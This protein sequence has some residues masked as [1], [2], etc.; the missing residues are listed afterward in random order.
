MV[1]SIQFR[2]SFDPHSHANTRTFP[3]NVV[4]ISVREII[5]LSLFRERSFSSRSFPPSLSL[6][7]SLQRILQPNAFYASSARPASVLSLPQHVRSLIVPLS[8]TVSPSSTCNHARI[9][10]T[11][12]RIHAPRTYS[13]AAHKN[14]PRDVLSL[15]GA[16]LA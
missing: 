5:S 12:A 4:T 15:S 13:H 10:F 1:L 9:L 16:H 8:P 2:P 6:S 3:R 14:V 7:L 11:H